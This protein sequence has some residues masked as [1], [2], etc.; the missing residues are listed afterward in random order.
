MISYVLVL[1]SKKI[2]LS[3]KRRKPFRKNVILEEELDGI[4]NLED[5]PRLVFIDREWG[6]WKYPLMVETLLEI[7]T[8]GSQT[9]YKAIDVYSV[10]DSMDEIVSSVSM[11]IFVNHVNMIIL[12]VDFSFG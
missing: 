9:F 4:G 1:F 3:L 10:T 5:L 11:R 2:I 8:K 7:L 12:G 6:I